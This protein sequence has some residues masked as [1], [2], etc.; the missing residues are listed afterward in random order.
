MKWD[1]HTHS[2][3]CPHGSKQPLEEYI[4]KAIQLGF[5]RYSITEHAPLPPSFTDPIP[6]QDSAMSMDQLEAYLEQGFQLKKKYKDQIEI[7]IG[8]EIDYIFGYE[9]E[10]KSFLDRYGP[11][12]EDAILS[13]HFLPVEGQWTCLDYSAELFEQ[14][15]LQHFPSVSHV[16]LF[17]YQM[18]EQ[19]VLADLGAYKPQR[20]G[21]FSLIEKFKKKYPP[22]DQKIWWG[23]ALKVLRLIQEQGY[24]LDFNTAGYRKKD[25]LERYPSDALLE[26]AIALK[27][28][29]VFGS[30]AHHPDDIGYRYDEFVSYFSSKKV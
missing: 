24:Q 22:T 1:A 2:P 17:Y 7:L 18:L 13:V 20:I 9:Q 28:P 21:H 14:E 11:R 16:Y 4:E 29:F 23:Q 19:A 12:L 3:F 26:Q 6:A 25:C 5:T 27:I 8:L 30:D 10:T 15:L